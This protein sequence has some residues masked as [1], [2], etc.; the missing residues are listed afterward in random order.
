MESDFTSNVQMLERSRDG[1]RERAKGTSPESIPGKINK[2]LEL[3]H[4]CKAVIRNLNK[5][6]GFNGIPTSL[7]SQCL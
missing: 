2:F 4:A 7:L 3:K 6:K 1:D 5:Q